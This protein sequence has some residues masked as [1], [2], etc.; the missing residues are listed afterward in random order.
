MPLLRLRNF[1]KLILFIVE[2][3]DKQRIFSF[4]NLLYS[5]NS[6]LFLNR[7]PTLKVCNWCGLKVFILF[8]EDTDVPTIRI[9]LKT[10]LSQSSIYFSIFMLFNS[11]IFNCFF[12]SSGDNICVALVEFDIDSLL[13]SDEDLLGL[14]SEFP[15]LLLLLPKIPL[16]P[17]LNVS[18]AAKNE[19]EPPP[20]K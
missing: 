18:L 9:F 3:L 12:I 11:L 20:E 13:K 6:T 10:S 2:S 19:L 16:R 1:I 7:F 15:L 4:N 8:G 5:V 17:L 14:I